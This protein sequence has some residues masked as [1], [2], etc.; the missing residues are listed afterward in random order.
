[1]G[2][3]LYQA[4]AELTT[5][6]WRLGTYPEQFKAARTVVL[7]KPD[8]DMYK[9]PGSWRPIALL[10]TIGKTMEALLARRLSDFA[11]KE[12]LLP[13]AQMGNRPSVDTAL[14][15]LLEQIHTTWHAGG[16]ATVLSL[17]ISR[18][19]DIVN[20]LRLLNKLSTKGL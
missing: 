2:P 16:V 20:H 9:E 6:C 11:E 5:A 10:N 14:E 12:G 3:P 17:D 13:D 19:F 1:M 7:R 18:A 4:V 15:L 8:K